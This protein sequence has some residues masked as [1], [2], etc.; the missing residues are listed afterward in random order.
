MRGGPATLPAGCTRGPGALSLSAAWRP[1]WRPLRRARTPTAPRCAPPPRARAGTARRHRKQREGRAPAPPPSR[2]APRGPARPTPV[3]PGGVTLESRL[4]NAQ[5]PRGLTDC[6]MATVPG[7][8]PREGGAASWARLASCGSWGSG[9][10]RAGSTVA[11]S[12][13][14]GQVMQTP[15]LSLRS[16]RNGPALSSCPRAFCLLFSSL[17]A[18]SQ[19][20]LRAGWGARPLP[21]SSHSHSRTVGPTS[22]KQGMHG[23]GGLRQKVCAEVT[24]VTQASPL[25]WPTSTQPH[26][27]YP[28]PGP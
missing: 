8:P 23:E 1:R 7:S 11:P 13:L 26:P 24:I 27:S 28:P 18:E 25:P 20:S 3:G 21:S 12:G 5:E 10:G 6:P 2:P 19:L 16:P 15:I 4:G 9:G 14:V 17:A 22:H